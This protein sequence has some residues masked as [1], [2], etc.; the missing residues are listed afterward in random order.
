[1]ATR[2]QQRRGTIAEWTAANPV[3]LDGEIGFETDTHFIRVGDGVTAFLDLIRYV[4]PQGPQGPQG[5]VGPQGT[6][7]AQGPQGPQGAMGARGDTGPQGST[8]P[9][10][11]TGLAGSSGPQGPTGPPGGTGPQGPAGPAGVQ[12]I[13]GPAGNPGASVADHGYISRLSV[14]IAANAS[15]SWGYS[16]YGGP[17]ITGSLVGSQAGAFTPNT[18]PSSTSVTMKTSYAGGALNHFANAIYN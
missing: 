1:M 5:A 17:S 14:N 3:L 11:A 6:L 13:Q 4:G 12:G 10:G 2:M 7:G 8:G 9:A 15:Y 18:F 16:M